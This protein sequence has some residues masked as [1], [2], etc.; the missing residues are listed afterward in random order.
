MT[1]PLMPAVSGKK[2]EQIGQ[3]GSK[4]KLQAI[5]PADGRI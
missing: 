5:Q 3:I 4:E 1:Y 2:E